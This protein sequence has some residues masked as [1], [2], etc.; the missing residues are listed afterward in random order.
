MADTLNSACKCC[1]TH[2]AN[3]GSCAGD[4]KNSFYYPTDCPAFDAGVDHE[5]EYEEM[6]EHM[7]EEYERGWDDYH[8]D[9]DPEAYF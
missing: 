1:L 5:A 9:Y 7:I 4:F 2:R 8:D 6:M 3:G